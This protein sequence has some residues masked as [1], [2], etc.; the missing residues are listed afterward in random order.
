MFT[1]ITCYRIKMNPEDIIDENKQ[2]LVEK[3][4]VNNTTL[5]ERL[6][7]L[8]LFRS[9]DVEQIVVSSN[10]TLKLATTALKSWLFKI[11]FGLQLK[12]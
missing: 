1:Q 11:H 8:G 3:I 5:W 9:G 12:K 4:D 6:I 10:V 7:E 2:R